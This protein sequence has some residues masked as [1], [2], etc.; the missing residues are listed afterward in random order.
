MPDA[1]GQEAFVDTAADQPEAVHVVLSV[2][3]AHGGLFHPVPLCTHVWRADRLPQLH[4][5]QG[6]L[7]QPL[8]G[9]GQLPAVLQQLLRGAAVRQHAAHQPVRPGHVPHPDPVRADAQRGA[10]QAVQEGRADGDLRPLF[11]VHRGVREPDALLPGPHHRRDQPGDRAARR[12]KDQ[13]H[14]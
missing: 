4:A 11:S 3:A 1:E 9:A 8:G 2:H 6:H 12:Q 14:Q 5:R 13:L 7:E 10:F